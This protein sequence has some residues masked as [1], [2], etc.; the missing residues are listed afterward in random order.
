MLIRLFKSN[1][2]LA[3][4][5]IFLI[6]IVSWIPSIIQHQ[7]MFFHF[8]YS[9]GILYKNIQPFLFLHKDFSIVFTFILVISISFLLVR[10]NIQFF[11]INVR[12]QLPALFYLVL[13][14]AFFPLNRANPALLA[15]LFIII[16]LF[17]IFNSYKQDQLSYQYF[18]S[19]ILISTGS[20]F[21]FNLIFFI[22]LLWTGLAILR[23][24]KWREWV[25]TLVGVSLPYVFLF[26]YYYLTD[27]RLFILWEN[28]YAQLT[29]ENINYN[30]STYFQLYL[31]FLL[32]LAAVASFMMIRKFGSKKIQ[33]RK[34][35]T[36]L[37]FFF[38]NSVLIYFLVPSAGIE[39]I[40][41]S[42]IPLTYLFSHYFI[43]V[44][45]NLINN[46]FFAITVFGVIIFRFMF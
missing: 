26:S 29:E 3:Y 40:Y 11:F 5:I 15:S 43:N 12:T 31:L 42:G 13:V 21:Y 2:P 22:P 39:I 25:F 1:N 14:C 27:R 6:V 7:W 37:L 19:A 4:L 20:L 44:Q 34:Y 17:K 46:F 36:F 30:F 10:L 9:P 35:F 8:D 28:L 41:F 18:D 16:A 24:F 38:I 45:N 23:N 33:A 32:V